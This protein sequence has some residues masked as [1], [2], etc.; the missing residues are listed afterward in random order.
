MKKNLAILYLA[1]A[2]MAS[3]VIASCD[4]IDPNPSS[5][6]S[7]TPTLAPSPVPSVEPSP[8][9]SAEPSPTPT[10]DPTAMRESL[11]NLAAPAKLSNGIPTNALSEADVDEPEPQPDE[12]AEATASEPPV[13][14]HVT[15]QKKSVSAS[16]DQSNTLR[17]D[18]DVIYP[19]SVIK[20]GSIDDG[21]YVE[22]TSGTK[23]PVTLSYS[24]SGLGADGVL[25]KT[26]V[27][28]LSATREFHNEVMSQEI[29]GQTIPSFQFES[30]EV[31]NEEAFDLKISAGA[32]YSSLV[33]TSV[34]AG[35][36]YATSNHKNKILVR[37]SQTFYTVDVDQAGDNFLYESLDLDAFGG[38]RP[39]YVSSVAYGR[40]GYLSVETSLSKSE[41]SSSL[42]VACDAGKISGDVE[43][44]AAKEK[45]NSTSTIKITLIG[46]ASS[47][48]TLDG[49]MSEIRD[50]GF[51]AD[52]RGVIIAYKLRF[53]DDNTI[54]N[55]IFTGEYT[56]RQ[57]I[58]YKGFYRI[59]M[60]IDKIYGTD[61]ESGGMEVYGN[62]YY[63]R[64]EVD[65]NSVPTGDKQ[66]LF[67]PAEGSY[68]TNGNS[69]NFS[70]D[71]P[72]PFGKVTRSYDFLLPTD[73]L[74]I[75]SVNLR[76]DD[77]TGDDKFSN[78]S[79]TRQ[80]SQITNGSPF[81]VKAYF[82]GS[83]SQYVIFTILPTVQV[84]YNET[85]SL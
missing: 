71:T 54:A 69:Y 47:P 23:R 41:F 55:T 9:P 73:T 80:V 51:S 53:V 29:P 22:V 74:S 33:T 45:I 24:L 34:K 11:R 56:S 79:V 57:T 42:S 40:V 19:G 3:I 31:N 16:Y 84:L 20:G 77:T 82:S 27:P 81:D 68:Y 64:G 59:G 49:F 12:F 38:Y 50:G 60:T 30:T 65:S 83:T 58:A 62:V 7:P 28:S 70:D 21:T 37:F 25:S 18:S 14:Y 17:P 67:Q 78:A 32:T 48:T 1:L 10:I 46:G 72:T 35:F 43:V 26:L 52:N 85:P 6:P 13:K 4:P 8:E 5:E 44:E 75:A 2:V 76:E 36:S 39:V 15:L 63:A 61:N 66:D